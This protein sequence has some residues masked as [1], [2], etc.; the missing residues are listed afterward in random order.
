LIVVSG[1]A[2]LEADAV[3]LI[4]TLAAVAPEAMPIM[5]EKAFQVSLFPSAYDFV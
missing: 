3:L 5:L 1:L 2:G 4:F